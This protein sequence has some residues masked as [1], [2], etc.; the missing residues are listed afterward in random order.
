MSW[1]AAIFGSLTIPAA[2]V[3][4]WLAREADSAKV[5]NAETYL[6]MAEVSG[7]TVKKT[8]AAIEKFKDKDGLGFIE[9][10][11]A[12]DGTRIDVR[13]FLCKD[14]YLERSVAL[15]S[16]WAAAGAGSVGEL[17]FAGMLTASFCQRLTMSKKGVALEP[18]AYG[19]AKKLPVYD[20]IRRRVAARAAELGVLLRSITVR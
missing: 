4:A 2:E 7:K 5:P 8:L 18:F 11:R 10:Q 15:A 3:K 13:A 20:E 6:S 19:V 12:E 9:L 14:D 17:Y 16:I 1:D